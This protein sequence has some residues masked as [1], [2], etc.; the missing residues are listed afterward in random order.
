MIRLSALHRSLMA[1]AMTLAAVGSAQAQNS[2]TAGADQGIEVVTVIGMRGS[3]MRSMDIKQHANTILDA[4]SAEELGKFPDR[5]VADALG[6]IPGVTVSRG[7]GAEGQTVT[8]RGLGEGFSTTTLNG[9]ILPSDSTSRAFAFDVLPSEMISGA[10]IRKAV[11][12]TQLEGSIG[13]AIDLRTARPFD[14]PGLH[15][16]GSMEGEYDD[17]PGQMGYKVT[18]VFSDTFNNDR[19]GLLMSLTYSRRHVRTDNLHEYTPAE[20]TEADDNVD[21]NGNGVIDNDKTYIRPDYYS[22]GVILADFERL[23]LSTS[24]QYKPNENL[25]VTLDALYSYYDAS[26]NN[27]AQ[28]NFMAPREDPADPAGVEKWDL[29]T[30]KVDQN[31]VVTNFAMHDLVAEVLDDQEPRIVHTQQYGGHATWTPL[32]RLTVDIDGYWS[33]ASHNE[34]G[35][36][37]FVVAGIPG[38]T[39][40]FATRANGFPDLAITI[41][42]GRTLDQATDAD[43]H[44]HYI[45]IQGDNLRDQIKGGQLDGKYDLDMYFIESVQAGF[46]YNQRDKD[47]S[48]FDN[49]YT[50]SCNYCGYPFTFADID[51]KVVHPLAVGNLL[52]GVKG[53][54]PR[55]FAMF[56]IDA[57]LAALPNAD[58][59]PAVLDPT[60]GLPYPA[61][62]STQIIQ[63]DLPMSFAISEKT[64]SGY[65][66]ANLAGE[67]WH[68]NVGLRIVSTDVKSAGASIEI[69]SITK[70]PGNTADYDVEISDPTPVTGG[71]QY[72]KLLPSANF[73]YDFTDQLRLRLA[74]S[75]VIA[76]PS[77]DQLSPASDA[78]SASSGTFIIYNSGNP[79]LKPTKANQL[80][81]SLEWYKSRQGTIALAV[82]YKDIKDFVTTV[83]ENQEI[84]GQ[85]FTVVTVQN[86]DSATVLGVELAA[87]YLFEDGYGFQANATYN[88]SK[89]HLGGLTGQLDG[90]I[91]FSF[92]LKTFYE[93]DGW[94]G[95][96]SYSYT[97]KFT[98]RISGI[99]PGLPEK[100]LAYSELSASLGYEIT[101]HFK[102]Y[103]EGSNLLNSATQRYSGY[104]NVPAYYES[105]GRSIFFG[106]RAKL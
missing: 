18:G 59:N 98:S 31:G 39:G 79:N 38:S 44:V 89:A 8:I 102:V 64:V 57:Y 56:D 22:M 41:P 33:Q 77:F 87:Q 86:G 81:A 75:Q 24:F 6:N 83:N 58:N 78:S 97:S 23:G 99:I 61:G 49:G 65:L 15:L 1:S 96:V 40:V 46:A 72:T 13:G 76:R 93:K 53:N 9:R 54:F 3:M 47:D 74:A 17:L 106:V 62:Y 90:A 63:K 66:Q 82:F 10:E 37:R 7:A 48:T 105:Y 67:R 36:N 80:D 51:A 32:D 101:S 70:L 91:P 25:V 50:T 5:N 34:G 20:V 2:D 60:T 28:S 85:D 42:G 55:N 4:I 30:L 88:H 103:V 16:S 71:G 43:Y 52:S 68:G 84:A 12:A 35:K 45:G 27:Y 26:T 95:Q 29:N 100:E 14:N 73:S 21:Y 69:L 19:M 92:N 94:D 104:T 11:D